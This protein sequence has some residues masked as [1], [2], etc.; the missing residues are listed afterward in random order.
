[1]KDIDLIEETL[2]IYLG[3]EELLNEIIK[4]LSTYQK[5]D[6]YNYICRMH[7]IDITDK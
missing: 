6:I 2:K 4:A 5:E 7:D 1:M 3:E